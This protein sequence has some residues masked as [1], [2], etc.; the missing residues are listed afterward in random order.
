MHHIR[1]GYFSPS[2]VSAMAHRRGFYRDAGLEV[3]EEAVKSSPQQFA[4]LRDGEYNLVV[5]APDNVATYRFNTANPLGEILDVRI[6]A[7]V[8]G[9]TG[10]SLITRPGIDSAEDLRGQRIAVDVPTSGFAI[11]LYAMLQRSGLS[12][13]NDVELVTAGSTPRRWAALQA[14]EFDATLLNAGFD[15]I[16]EDAG[17][18]RFTRVDDVAETYLG[19]VIASTAATVADH[20]EMVEQFLSAWSEALDYVRQPENRDEVVESIGEQYSVDSRLAELITGVLLDPARGG[21]LP[22]TGV[23][24]DG[25]TSVLELRLAHGAFASPRTIEE[26]L[27]PESQLIAP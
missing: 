8:D 22:N 16:A 1:L 2:V 5:T 23:P 15:I 10:L 17:F 7:G 27:A 6:L 18:V 24:R 11:A 4:S 13:D 25:L 3:E 20:P 14:G 21:L 12:A 26:M 9:G 19:S